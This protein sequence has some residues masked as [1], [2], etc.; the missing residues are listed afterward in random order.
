[1]PAP[2]KRV[3]PV[4]PPVGQI[5]AV[6]AKKHLTVFSRKP[7]APGAGRPEV[8]AAFTRCAH[9]TIGMESRQD[10]NAT[11]KTCMEGKG[12]RTGIY[13]RKSRAKPGS[14]L[15]GHVY[16]SGPGRGG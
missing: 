1:M 2:W 9:E 7:S 8:K 13:R 14:P 5:Q 10:R 11:L 6:S 3:S 15:F 4:L 16:E 12:L